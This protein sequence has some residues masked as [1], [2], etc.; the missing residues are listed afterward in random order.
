M[1]RKDLIPEFGDIAPGDHLALL[2]VTEEERDAVTGLYLLQGLERGE[3]LVCVGGESVLASAQE[4]LAGAGADVGDMVRRGQLILLAPQDVYLPDGCFQ[5]E[6]TLLFW[7]D[8][9][10]RVAA[11]GWKALRV[12]GDMSWCLPG[13]SGVEELARYEAEVNRLALPL[14]ATLLCAYDLE[15]FPA[16]TIL[17]VL[18]THPKVALGSELFDNTYYLPPGEFLENMVAHSVLAYHLAQLRERKRALREI[19]AARE[20][21]EAIV[22]TVREPLLVLDAGLRVITANR[23]FYRTFQANVGET[24]GKPL[25]E[26]GNG[27]WDIPELR[28]L[29]EEVL[30]L[31]TSFEAYEVEHTFPRIGRRTMLLNA[32][33]VYREKNRTEMVLLAIED[34]TQRKRAEQELLRR[35]RYFHHLVENAYDGVTVLDAEGRHVYASP[36][37]KAVLG[38]EPEQLL[39]KTPFEFMHP[40][41]VPSVLETFRDGLEHPGTVKRIVH[42]FRDAEGRW[43]YI[44]SSGISL[45]DNPHVRGVVINFRD[46]TAR[47]QAEERVRRLNRMF[48]DLG[49]DFFANME[50]IVSACRDI[51]EGDLAA[52]ARLERGRLLLL[53]TAP[54]EGGF[55]PVEEPSRFLGWPLLSGE[56]AGALM[57]SLEQPPPNPS[58]LDP[59]VERYGYVSFLAYPVRCRERTVG[60]LCV[61]YARDHQRPGELIREMLPAL[62][63]T[64]AIEEER[65]AREEGLKDFIDIAS[66]ELRHPITLVKGYALSLKERWKSLPDEEAYE[67]LA[68]IDEGSDR[69]TRLVKGLLDV[70]GI[71]RGQFRLELRDTELLPLVQKALHEAGRPS[72]RIRLRCRGNIGCCR[73]DPDRFL[74]V[75]IILLENACKFSPPRSPIQ[76]EMAEREDHYRISVFDRGPGIP[77]EERER[78]FDRFYQ[79]EKAPYH[80]KPGL[81][82]GLYV[83]REIVERHGG[84]IWY[85][86]RKGGGSVFRFTIPASPVLPEA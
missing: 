64:L 54:G 60:A 11:A 63:R 71:E 6:S 26:L 44:E 33:R 40:E 8:M 1:E 66:H 52:Y 28:R 80:S 70:S 76:V 18:R 5:P 19:Q 21:A 7:R 81:G 25:Y 36:S 57:I 20:Y 73:L 41:D 67:M 39:G 72:G 14:D 15:R 65:L 55:I 74:E 53:T 23:S 85:E 62:A 49:A 29:L 59:L 2:Y 45:L 58:R 27:Q 79:V 37:V 61:Y 47:R 86:A 56:H 78:V 69:L 83:A 9:A 34:I 38:W 50:T 30:P 75:M 17:D 4:S 42:R 12:A 3:K 68:A 16:E 77:K 35:E 51:L 13:P 82:M 32:R 43:R 48:L 84:K 24:E 22:E 10:E 46:I 31:N